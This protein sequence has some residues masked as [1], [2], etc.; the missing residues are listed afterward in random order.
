MKS[1]LPSPSLA[2]YRH[3]DILNNIMIILD[4]GN[5]CVDTIFTIITMHCFPDIEDNLFFE[6]GGPHLHTHNMHIILQHFK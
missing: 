4:H 3:Y 6:N 5:M 2:I 1:G